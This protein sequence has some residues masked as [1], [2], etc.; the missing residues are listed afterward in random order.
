MK[1]KNEMKNECEMQNESQYL[2]IENK[3]LNLIFEFYI[4][5][6]LKG[7]KKD[8]E[9]HSEK[10]NMKSIKLQIKLIR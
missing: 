1:I 3:H 10:F 4:F 7:Y 5:T 9:V 8:M 2:K 6:I